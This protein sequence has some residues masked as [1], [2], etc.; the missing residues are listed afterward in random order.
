[1]DV[2]P[3]QQRQLNEIRRATDGKI[4]PVKNQHELENVLER[5]FEI[6]PVIAD[7]KSV[8][9][10]LN[11]IIEYLNKSIAFLNQKSYVEV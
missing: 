8:L 2:P 7:I 6:E 5:L 9:N 3:D 4:F 11:S 10:I 1:M